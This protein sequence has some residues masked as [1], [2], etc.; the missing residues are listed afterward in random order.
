MPKLR[1]KLIPTS[2]TV[3][4]MDTPDGEDGLDTLDYHM[5]LMDIPDTLTT[6]MP[7]AQL[8]KLSK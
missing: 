8:S 1:L 6:H 4:T 3:D 2:C 5:V 7:S